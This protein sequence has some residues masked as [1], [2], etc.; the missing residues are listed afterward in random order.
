[1]PDLQ[2]A[3]GRICPNNALRSLPFIMKHF[4]CY[5]YICEN[6]ITWRCLAQLINIIVSRLL[7]PA[8]YYIRGNTFR[9]QNSF[10][11]PLRFRFHFKIFQELEVN[12]DFV[13]IGL[14]W[15]T[16][17]PWCFPRSIQFLCGITQIFYW[18]L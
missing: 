10:F 2:L 16:S 8:I 17:F 11:F 5:W 14:I 4:Y 6:H 1:M 15:T 13:G 7:L 9:W 3:C 18:L 12:V